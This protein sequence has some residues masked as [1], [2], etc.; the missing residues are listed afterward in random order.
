[1]LDEAKAVDSWFVASAELRSENRT[2]HGPK[3]VAEG[4][5]ERPNGASRAPWAAMAW[6]GMFVVLSGYTYL[7]A[8]GDETFAP[9][10]VGW[11]EEAVF[12]GVP[13][14]FLQQHLYERDLIWLDFA[15]YVFHVSWFMVPYFAAFGIM[16]AAR[17]RLLEYFGWLV[18]THYLGVVFY[19]LL[20]VE[21]PWMEIGTTRVL[22][23]RVFI[24]FTRAD[25]NPVAAFPSLHCAVPMALAL[26]FLLRMK[27]P[28]WAAVFA[29]WGVGISFFVVYLGEHWVIDVVGAYALAGM[30]AFVLT[31]SHI[32]RAIR[33]I[34]GDPAQLVQRFNRHAF[35]PRATVSQ[36]H[37]RAAK[38]PDSRA[39]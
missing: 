35:P 27:S 7:R 16:V 18:A 21:P 13:S 31:S 20:P 15:G 22:D 36:L 24:P 29:A 4:Q 3:S 39:A 32:A 34:P 8:M 2:A 5:R 26:F 6:I 30:V 11:L 1:M 25:N 12:G 28:R 17:H 10:R 9:R 38:Q 19:I 33:S 14:E 23:E 37:T